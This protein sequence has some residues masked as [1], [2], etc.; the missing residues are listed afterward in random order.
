MQAIDEI[1][2]I[3]HNGDWHKVTEIAKRIRTQ[4]SKI[5]LISRFLSTYDFIEYDKKSKRIKLSNELQ[6]FFER[7]TEIEQEES[8]RKNN[9]LS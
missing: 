8:A 4:E 2:D 9:S 3:I 6:D 1:L 5:E 7:I